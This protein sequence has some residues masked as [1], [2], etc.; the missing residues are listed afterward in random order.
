MR[1]EMESPCEKRMEFD[2]VAWERCDIL[3]EDWKDKTFN[4]EQFREIGMIMLDW[5]QGRPEELFAP[6]AGAFNAI[7]QMKFRDGGSILIRFPRPG[8]SVFPEEKLQ[9]EVAVMR[10]LEQQ[11]S[12]P[13]PH[14]LHHVVEKGGP[15]DLGPY[16]IMEYIP[17]EHTLTPALET[18]G[19]SIEDRPILDP[20][21]SD[22]RLRKAYSQLADIFIE[23]AKPSFSAIGCI[24]KENEDDEF[25]DSWV[26]AHRAMTFSMNEL[27]SVGNFPRN[28]LPQGVFKT[29]SSYYLALAETHMLHLSTQHNDV[30]SSA[31]DCRRKYVARCLFRKLAREGKLHDEKNETGP[32]KLFCD[33]FRPENVL[34]NAQFDIVAAID[35][36]FTYAAPA[37]FTYSPPFWLLL[38][39]PEYWPEGLE[40]WTQTYARRLETFLDVLRQREN[41][42]IQRGSLL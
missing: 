18:P 41:A 16:I 21:I 39:L 34:S 7:M 6:K 19:F 26:V 32:F 23:L 14:V 5:R 24:A 3:F 22:E 28:L 38:E 8:S 13:V 29:A 37:A 10:F 33:D 1:V 42:A 31:E 30:I 15:G 2:D 36:E 40:D 27:V 17:N 20:N 25:D 9:R 4:Q 12:I 11:T 35:W